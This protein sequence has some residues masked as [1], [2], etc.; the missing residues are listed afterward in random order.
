MKAASTTSRRGTS[1]MRPP[2]RL[3]R[4]RSRRLLLWAF[5]PRV[6][7]RFCRGVRN[8]R[9][10]NGVEAAR[11]PSC[12]SVDQRRYLAKRT[13]G[14]PESS[15]VHGSHPRALVIPDALEMMVAAG[16]AS[17]GLEGFDGR[18]DRIRAETKAALA[19]RARIE[20]DARIDLGGVERALPFL[21]RSD[22]AGR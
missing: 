3:A 21:D 22:L 14:Q 11:N 1:V 6:Q 2:A 17:G 10:S 16:R 12:H 13:H 8:A 4:K 20:P 9:S 18:G 5:V 19:L 15:P 7:P